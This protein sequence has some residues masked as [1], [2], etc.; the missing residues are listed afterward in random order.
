MVREL[1]CTR[2][3]NALRRLQTMH[4]NFTAGNAAASTSAFA[5]ENATRMITFLLKKFVSF[6]EI[7]HLRVEK[8]LS[9]AEISRC[10]GACI[11][12]GVLSDAF[13]QRFLV[14]TMFLRS[15]RCRKAG[16]EESMV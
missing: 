11:F 14:S 3:C 2:S 4:M 16:I 1:Q 13:S 9:F 6:A 8:C 15:F 10:L 12:K 7:D 5:N